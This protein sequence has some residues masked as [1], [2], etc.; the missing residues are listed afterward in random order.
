MSWADVRGWFIHLRLGF[1]LLLSPIFLWGLM[2]GGGGINLSAIIGF[3]S[4]HLFGYAGGTAFN[5]FFDRDMGPVGGLAHPPPSPRGLLPFSL[6][7][8][9]SG[10]VLAAAVNLPFAAIYLS[11]FSL[12]VL[13]SHPRSRFKGKPVLAL[14][15]V[16]VGQ[17]FLAYLGG[18]ACARGE[19]LSAFTLP[20]L[21]GAAASVGIT[22]GLYP[23]TEIYQLDEDRERGD[24]TMAI[25]LG[26]TRS[27]RFAQVLL[28]FGGLAAIGVVLARYRIQEAGL[29]AIFVAAIVISVERWSG[30]FGRADVIG[31][32]HSL[33]RLY[34]ATCLGFTGWIALHLLG[35]L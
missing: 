11:M 6:A 14:L 31:N 10:L 27:F 28:A 23:L 4:F 22:L 35:W 7:W 33:M 9:A 16:A 29:I 19:I 24:R 17:G 2:L 21:V 20:G 34:A 12:S 15:T 18:W 30:R 1:Q 3:V 5:S 25:W 26:P 13:Y 8:Q 32:F